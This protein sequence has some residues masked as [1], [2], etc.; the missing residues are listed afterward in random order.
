MKQEKLIDMIRA[1]DVSNTKKFITKKKYDFLELINQP[2]EDYETIKKLT[3]KEV[4][5]LTRHMSHL[6][7][8]ASAAIPIICHGEL[9][10]PMKEGCPLIKIDR[11]RREYD[12]DAP[13][14]LKLGSNCELEINLLN[15]WTMLYMS[16]YEINQEDFTEFMMV[17]ELAEVELMLWRINNNLAKPEHAEFIQESTVGFDNNGN[18]LTK[19]EISSLFD[20]KERLINRKHRLIKLMVGDRQEKYK[21]DAALKIRNTDDPSTNAAKLRN[22]IDRLIVQAKSLDQKLKEDGGGI[23]DIKEDEDMLTPEDLIDEDVTSD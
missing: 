15:E 17:R 5:K 1:A 8:G 10:C 22:Q 9:R 4:K 20:A 19:R 2:P 14:V 21:R 11:E 16:E 7:T 18:P 3:P 13:S 6:I 12:P 23:I